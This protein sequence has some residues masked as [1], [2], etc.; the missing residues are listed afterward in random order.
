MLRLSARLQT[1]IK[2]LSVDSGMFD[3]RGPTNNFRPTAQMTN[4]NDS[5]QTLA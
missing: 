3:K 4:A 5:A 1:P 2:Q